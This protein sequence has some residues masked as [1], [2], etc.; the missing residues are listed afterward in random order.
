MVDA[1]SARSAERGGPHGFDAAKKVKGGKRHLVTDTCGPVLAVRVL[2]GDVR[3]RDGAEPVF[4]CAMDRY[5]SVSKVWAD[6]GYAGECSRRPRERL[7]FDVEVLRRGCH[8][9]RAGV[10]GD[11]LV[12][13]GS[14]AGGE[15]LPR[16]WLI[17]RGNARSADHGAWPRSTTSKPPSVRPG[18]GSLTPASM[19]ADSPTRSLPL[20][21]PSIHEHLLRERP[22]P[23]RSRARS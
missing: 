20:A 8:G 7:G 14:A 19:F 2:G 11:Q 21:V 12:L 16:R 23:T 5:S 18:C 6:G 4:A 9:A 10:V 13:P 1:Q 15:L 3:D 17:E 22:G